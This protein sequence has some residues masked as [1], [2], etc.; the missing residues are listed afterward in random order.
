MFGSGF[1]PVHAGTFHPRLDHL[2][3][4]FGGSAAN[5]PVVLSVV[6]VANR[7]LVVFEIALSF[8][9]RLPSFGVFDRMGLEFL[10]PVCL[11]VL[12]LALSQ[13]IGQPF[14]QPLGLFGPFSVDRLAALPEI[15]NGVPPI[16]DVNGSGKVTL[17]QGGD[18]RR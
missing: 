11:H 6:G 3:G 9:I 1:A 18:P 17:R 4:R 5:R 16:T 2:A 12:H 10:F 15:L 8:P 13:K 14:H 7:V